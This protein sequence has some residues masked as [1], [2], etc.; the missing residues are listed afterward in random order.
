MSNDYAIRR[1]NE[2]YPESLDRAINIVAGFRNVVNNPNIPKKG[3]FNL[4]NTKGETKEENK[5]AF[6]QNKKGTYDQSK[7][8]CYHCKKLGH[9][10]KDCPDKNK[11]AVTN[12]QQSETQQN[13]NNNNSNNKGEVCHT[14]FGFHNITEEI[15]EDK[16]TLSQKQEESVLRSWLLLDNQS[17]TDIFCDA[18]LLTNIKTV[19]VTL[20]LSTNAGVMYCNEK[21]ELKGYGE[22]W[23][24]KEA[25]TNILSLKNVKKV[26]RVTYDSEGTDTFEVYRPQ[27]N[28]KFKCSPEGL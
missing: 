8:Q 15:I 6:A 18:S 23:Y 19:N 25:I 2:A 17:T 13:D 16:I 20:R 3:K 14:Q 5:V 1:N 27:G 10:A 7:V 12:T 28:L 21:G 22:V 26:Y 11:P 9:Y 24:H 4:K